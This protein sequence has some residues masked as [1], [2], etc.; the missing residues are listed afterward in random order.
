M[1]ESKRTMFGGLL[2]LIISAIFALTAVPG[3]TTLAAQDE[4]VEDPG[5]ARVRIVHASPDA[6]PVDVYAGE[7]SLFV[8]LEFASA[9]DYIM[10]PAGEQ[11]V[12]V[13]PAGGSVDDAAI[14]VSSEFADG[15]TYEIV[16]GGL[17]EEIEGQIYEVNRGT[18]GGNNTARVRVIHAAIGV[19]AVDVVTSGGETLF[20]GIEPGSA[21]DYVE[22]EAATLDL[23]VRAAGST[24]AAITAPGVMVEAGQV[25]DI[26]A[27]GQAEDQTLQLL[28]LSTLALPACSE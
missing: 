3:L 14:D 28:P 8:G 10:I 13:V 17:R 18:L 5:Q 6:G 20:T 22:I 4:P 1:T 16:A 27:I 19:E 11:Q 21:T 15:G 26:F 2:T 25:Y 9:S 12:R 24:E 7:E 23:E